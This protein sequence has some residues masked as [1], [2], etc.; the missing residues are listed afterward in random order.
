MNQDLNSGLSLCFK[1]EHSHEYEFWVLVCDVLLFVF[2]EQQCFQVC[3]IG[4]QG[5]HRSSWPTATGRE[6]ELRRAASGEVCLG[7]VCGRGGVGGWAWNRA[8]MKRGPWETDSSGS[9]K[10]GHFC[11]RGPAWQPHLFCPFP[12]AQPD[13]S[14]RVTAATGDVC[15]SSV[16]GLTKALRTWPKP[17]REVGVGGGGGRAERCGQLWAGV[18]GLALP[19]N[20]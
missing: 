9:A 17:A 10:K 7:R 8:E 18:A 6:V 4:S 11:P 20:R 13:V 2:I 12:C 5:S 15:R 19:Q 1:P 16:S 3:P 14:P